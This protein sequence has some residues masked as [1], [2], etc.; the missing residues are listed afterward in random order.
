[1]T[2]IAALL[3]SAST[4][5]SVKEISYFFDGNTAPPVKLYY[6]DIEYVQVKFLNFFHRIPLISYL[7]ARSRGKGEEVRTAL[8]YSRVN[9]I[10]VRLNRETFWSLKTSGN[11]LAFGQLPA[12]LTS[13][14]EHLLVQT[15][16]I[17][18]YITTLTEIGS[19]MYPRD[20]PIE[21]ACIDALLD[22][23]SDAFNG[24]TVSAYPSRMGFD[25]LEE[26]LELKADIRKV[27]NDKILPNHL[28]CLRRAFRNKLADDG[29]WLTGR[30]TPSIA[31]FAW[32]HRFQSLSSGIMD[33]IDKDIVTGIDEFRTM[34]DTFNTLP[35]IQEYRVKRDSFLVQK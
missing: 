17:L 8:Y 21:A 6:F 29:P 7:L 3:P 24:L 32:F 14:G 23:E 33:G 9:F 25:F 30:T 5:P 35:S 34:M 10:D 18:R 27:L 4:N 12:L 2:P 26:Q 20:N 31:D 28:T 19:S 11:S 22:F 15:N 13:D 1:M 16:A